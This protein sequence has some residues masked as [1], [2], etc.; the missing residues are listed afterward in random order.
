MTETGAGLHDGSS[1]ADATSHLRSGILY[2]GA[3]QVW[4]AAG[5]YKPTTG[6]DRGIS[7]Q[8]KNGVAVYGGFTGVEPVLDMRDPAVNLTIL[9]GD[10]GIPD[11]AST[12]NRSVPGIPDTPGGD[13]G[14]NSYH[15]IHNPDLD[16]VEEEPRGTRGGSGT[17]AIDD[18]AVLDGFI[19]TAGNADGDGEVGSAGGGMLNENASPT[20]DGCTF[21]AN[22]AGDYGGAMQN[23]DRSD[24]MVTNC[25]F[26]GKEAD[27]DGGAVENYL[28]CSPTFI[29]C[30]FDGNSAN[31]AGE[32]GLG[33]AMDNY[34]NCSPTITN[35]TFINNMGW[36]GG[37]IQNYYD[38]NP[39]ITDCT[40]SG[41]SAGVGGDVRGDEGGGGDGAGGGV[42]NEE[43]S[44]TLT[45][46]VF[47][48]N[49]AWNGGAIHNNN[50]SDPT[51][52]NCTITGNFAEYGGGIYNV[53]S[54][55]VLANCILWG[56]FADYGSNVYN[57]SSTP[58]FLHCIVEGSGAGRGGNL[59]ED[60]LFVDDQNP[61]G[62]DGIPR[63]DDDGLRLL[64]GSPAIDAGTDA[65]VPPT[66]I[67]GADR[68]L[69]TDIGAYESFLPNT[70]PDFTAVAQNAVA[71]DLDWT[72][73]D[74][75][76]GYTIERS[77]N[78]T[79]GWAAVATPAAD[80]TTHTD[81]GL[82]PDTT[83]YYRINASNDDG[84][85]AWSDVADAT[86]D[87]LSPDGAGIIYVNIVTMGAGDG[88]SW[89]N[90]TS[91]FQDAIDT[92]GVIQVW[93]AA[94]TY[95][96][97]DD[98]DRTISFQLRNGVAVYGGFEGTETELEARDP[99]VNPTI[100]SG[101]IGAPDANSYHVIYN[102]DLFGGG[103]IDQFRGDA[104]GI[105]ETAVLDG[106]T[107]T[108]GLADGIGDMGDVGGGI[109]NENAS[110]TIANCA[111]VGNTADEVGG[112]VFNVGSSP[113]FTNCTIGGNTTGDA[114]GGIYNY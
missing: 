110:P 82:A 1:W 97:T 49:M 62:A 53:V 80:A 81:T 79:T 47:I 58:G 21:V 74:R 85:S 38:S 44:P 14:D 87:P 113:T 111:V 10:I 11:G 39:A 94:G 75:E 9:S 88:S 5:T 22:C 2:S 7:F 96:P 67:T 112:G 68:I 34:E 109:L 27:S 20:I 106:F 43:S 18:T 51:L 92:L 72:D 99:E 15:V 30:L 70:P 59:D 36:Y 61:D 104:S 66:D 102:P 77:A 69:P 83:Y 73:S 31:G 52:I 32:G 98:L 108:A 48:D 42:Y 37:A 28:F 50:G 26:T 24:P 29:D 8:L 105:D 107:I 4:V 78:G 17:A 23:Y 6:I 91:L 101:D 114:G 16:P 40:F 60:P 57:D 93:V 84:D 63:T 54:G 25:T 56:N 46:C 95:Y 89:A 55:P 86:T 3:T 45:N 65:G 19:V 33:G 41:N 13:S 71:I 103:E 90:A 100:L 76:T 12:P 64:G 35:C